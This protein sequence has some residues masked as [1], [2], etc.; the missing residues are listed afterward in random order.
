MREQKAAR[1]P[2]PRTT[3]ETTQADGATTQAD[4]VPATPAAK[5]RV[6]KPAKPK[7][8]A[9]AAAPAVDAS[10]VLDD[11]PPRSHN[12]TTGPSRWQEP[13][14]R[15]REAGGKAVLIGVQETQPRAA[16]DAQRI[17]EALKNGRVVIDGA[18]EV[19]ARTERLDDGSRRYGVWAKL[20]K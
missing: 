19:V 20:V 16:R 14:E 1:K 17:R 8:E 15:V 18:F 9:P 12:T 4:G 7:P 11:F 10:V 6:R 3:Q 2:V 5:P 13:L